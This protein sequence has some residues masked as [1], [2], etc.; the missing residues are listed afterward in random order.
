MKLSVVILNYNVRYFLELCLKSVEDAVANI[1]AEIIVID[2]NSSDDSCSMVKQL[3]P[4]VKLIENREN[5]GFSK[6]N[7][8]AVAEA[9]GEYLCILNPDTVVAEDTFTK[10]LNFSKSKTNLGIV[11]CQLIDGRGRFLPESKRNIPT[12]KVSLKKVL[13]KTNDYYANDIGIGSIRKVD[14]LVGAFMWLKKEVYTAV[15]GFDESYFMYG[16]D[17]ELSYKVLKAGYHNYYFGET[18]VIHFKGESTLKDAT[19][20]KRF[21]G[22]MQIFYK[23][24]FKQNILFN[25]VV[26]FGIK[27]AQF[28]NKMP[29]K[30]EIASKRTIVYTNGIEESLEV[31]LPKP[32]HFKT[33]IQ[34]K[35][36]HHSMV[37]YDF[38]IL[39]ISDIICDMKAMSKQ[40]NIV[41]RFLPK[42]SKF[43]LGSDSATN[44]G[45]VLHF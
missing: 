26:W 17:I 4:F 5:S 24:H 13:G 11:G 32:V 12:P 3:F 41:F 16:E 20:A 30:V 44:R 25:I 22:A 18:T 36:E 29:Q 40:E 45:E 35:A 33:T 27:L 38:N 2:N 1:D 10:L 37:I 23:K 28:L 8:I 14:I 34:N 43:I 21:Y 31:Q 9:K 42:S 39:K 6:G 19:Y 7:N 15:S